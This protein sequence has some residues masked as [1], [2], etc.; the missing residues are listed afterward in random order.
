MTM[1][2]NKIVLL[3]ISIFASVCA[4]GAAD[5]RVERSAP[6]Y[7]AEH[8]KLFSPE[9]V[10]VGEWP[11]WQLKNIDNQMSNSVLIEG[12]SGLIVFDTGASRA[13]GE[14]ILREIR[15]L[16]DKPVLAVIY[17][18][19][20]GDHTTGAGAIIDPAVATASKVQVIARDNLV[21]EYVDEDFLTGPIQTLRSVYMFGGALDERDLEDYVIGLG[22]G[23][24]PSGQGAFVEPNVD[25]IAQKRLKIGGVDIELIPTGGESA[26]HMIGWL[27]SQ[28][29][30]LT[31]DEIYPALPNIHSLRGT[32]FR[33]A[34][35]WIDAIDTIIALRPNFVV[36]SHGPVISGSENIGN[37]LSIYRDAIQYQHDQAVRLINKGYTAPEIA[38]TL[39]EL[40]PELRLDPYTREMYG[41]VRH[42]V[43]N[44]FH[45]YISWFSGD[46]IDLAPTPQRDYA[47]RMVEL[48]GGRAKLLQTMHSSYSDGEV[49][50]AGE[51]ATLLLRIDSE[52]AEARQIK[53]AVLRTLGY[54]QENSNWR[55]WYL[56][57]ANELDGSF[58]PTDAWQE[59]RKNVQGEGN[60]A[61][62]PAVRVL[63]LLRYRIDP[64]RVGNNRITLAWYIGEGANPIYTRLRRGVFVVGAKPFDSEA[65]TVLH[66]ERATLDA[67][68]AG[69]FDFGELVRAGRIT[70]EGDPEAAG[71]L[72]ALQ[73]QLGDRVTLSDR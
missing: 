45:G 52:D 56:T 41:T 59:L 20:H 63:D 16:S 73:D 50:F 61:A 49:Q 5:L 2:Q 19:H 14:A 64:E 33:D 13:H 51:L 40:P 3:L 48:T 55:S 65:E 32:K 53:S 12:E 46:A 17:S 30:V 60:L 7:L 72:F 6:G 28:R 44:I 21:S 58:D 22:G 9:V 34:R 57:A 47:R 39:N 31:G 10:Q 71:R 18:H 62:L 37:I 1:H 26:S 23:E 36:P 38:E 29:I 8:R 25:I 24:L 70:I 66:M 35:N 69:S 68:V 43:P 42:N 15:T 54:Q 11:V 67:L 27:A 4:A